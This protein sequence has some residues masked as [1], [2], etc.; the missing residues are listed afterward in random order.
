MEDWIRNIGKYLSYLV[1]ENFGEYAYDIVDGIAK[2]RTGEEL[3]ENVYKALRLAPKLEKK[4]RERCIFW[5]PSPADI[6][7]LENEVERL[8]DKPKE[9]RALALK[10]ALWAFAYWDHCPKEGQN[11]S[12]GGEN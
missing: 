6:E 7:A 8:S 11:N 2:A 1:D 10:L 12:T 5:K 4:A 3:L 9:L